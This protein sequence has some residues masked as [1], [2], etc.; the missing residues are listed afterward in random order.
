MK[1]IRYWNKEKLFSFLCFCRYCLACVRMRFG[2]EN[3][4]GAETEK[5][6][7]CFSFMTEMTE[8][9]TCEAPRRHCCV[10]VEIQHLSK[11]SFTK[12]TS[13]YHFIVHYWLCWGH[14]DRVT[15]CY[16]VRLLTLMA[17]P[18]L[19][20]PYHFAVTYFLF[21]DFIC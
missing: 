15:R 8:T 1:R 5:N 2:I 16:I 13:N 12:V 17:I 9:F 11:S 21:C 18:L 19:S 10:R 3:G 14:S 7:Y 6:V 20:I 4:R